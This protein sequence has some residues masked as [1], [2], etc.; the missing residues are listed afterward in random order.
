MKKIILLFLIFTIVISLTGC[1]RRGDPALIKDYELEEVSFE[2]ATKL[3]WELKP[4]DEAYSYVFDKM[5]LGYY[6]G[7]SNGTI[8][9]TFYGFDLEE[10]ASK[11]W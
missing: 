5:F 8:D 3:E 11:S 7:E 1:V 4:I 9:G 6:H 2:K 10:S